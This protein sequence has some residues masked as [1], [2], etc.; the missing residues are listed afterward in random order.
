MHTNTHN[1]DEAQNTLY[2]KE[3]N[4]RTKLALPPPKEKIFLHKRK[5]MKKYI[6][7]KVQ[8]KKPTNK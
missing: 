6:F 7:F 3:K 2:T 5:Q 1:K 4:K 8:N